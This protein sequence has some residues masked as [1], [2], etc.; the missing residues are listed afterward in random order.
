MQKVLTKF[1]KDVCK[2]GDTFM[3]AEREEVIELHLWELIFNI[4]QDG[5]GF[6]RKLIKFKLQ[7][8]S[9]PMGSFQSPGR[10]YS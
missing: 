1:Y 3:E 4:V 10:L 7:E 6:T 8:H 2:E 5:G 9:L